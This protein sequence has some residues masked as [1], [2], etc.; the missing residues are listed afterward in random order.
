[1][2]ALQ[3]NAQKLKYLLKVRENLNT[4]IDGSGNDYEQA[5]ALLNSLHSILRTFTILENTIRKEQLASGVT[6][7]Q[8][9]AIADQASAKVN[10][11]SIICKLSDE[12]VFTIDGNV[13]S[14]VVKLT[15]TGSV[16]KNSLQCD[17][18]TLN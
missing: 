11:I 16:R 18:L 8:L 3:T 6:N 17:T 2:T 15:K 7:E 1:M 12:I 5:D 14:Y 9:I 4:M 13:E 10:D